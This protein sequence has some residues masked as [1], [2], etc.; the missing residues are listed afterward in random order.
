MYKEQIKDYHEFDGDF[1]GAHG[2]YA[3]Q[4]IFDALDN[5]TLC[6]IG[7]ELMLDGHIV[8]PGRFIVEQKD[9][10]LVD[11][12]KEEL[13]RSF[14]ISKYE[15]IVNGTFFVDA[16]SD[17]QAACKVTGD[18]STDIINRYKTLDGYL[19]ALSLEGK[20]LSVVNK[21]WK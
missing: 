16:S 5:K 3:P 1:V 19:H 17:I 7:P 18:D 4:W 20:E 11:C 15:V 6:F 2:R 12:S 13:L 9:G 14:T 8:P 10:R 21:S